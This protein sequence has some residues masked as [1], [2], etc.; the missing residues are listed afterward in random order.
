[1]RPV[2]KGAWPTRKNSANSKLKFNAWKRAIPKLRAR[3]GEFCHLCEMAIN[4]Q[5]A[6]EHIKSRLRYPRLASS[7]TNFLL[8]CS[9]CN[10][11]KSSGQLD[12]PYR[13]RYFWP[14]IHN[15]LLAFEVPI[16]GQDFGI[17]RP[18]G[19]LS[20]DPPLQQRAKNMIDLYAL[21]Q[22]ETADGAADRRYIHRVEA[23]QMATTRR[24]EYEMNQAT[25]AAIVDMARKTGFFTVWFTVFSDVPA[26]K[27]ALVN[28]P[29]FGLNTAWFDAAYEP[30]PRTTNDTL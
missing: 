19:S 28:A 5:I 29:G 7:W 21:D 15:T 23:I 25:I 13:K 14:H 12:L 10:S 4:H 16:T 24:V 26:V 18:R 6:I 22:T 3:T 30:L 8:A 17:V 9:H 20:A 1:M 11:R 27:S 2:D